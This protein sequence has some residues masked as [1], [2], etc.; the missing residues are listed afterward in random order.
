[1]YFHFLDK[2]VNMQN[3]ARNV[4]KFMQD[5]TRNEKLSNRFFT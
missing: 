3:E 1:M 2:V 4:Y 5:S